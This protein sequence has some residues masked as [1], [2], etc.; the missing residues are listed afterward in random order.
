MVVVWGEKLYGKVD[1]VPGLFYVATRFFYLQFLPL[2]PLGSVLVLEGSEQG[3]NYRGCHIKM[4]F[5]SVLMAWVRCAALI[6]GIVFAVV[7]VVRIAEGKD[8]AGGS[9]L[10]ASGL[11]RELM[12][13]Y[14]YRLTRARVERALELAAQI[15]IPPE[16]IAQAF[17]NHYKLPNDD[18]NS[19]ETQA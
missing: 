7:G 14:S 16:V 5:K 10:I 17:A 13:A 6:G 15:G 9:G 19:P 11:C 12:L 3:D 1:Q 4:S 2:I 8:A 18:P